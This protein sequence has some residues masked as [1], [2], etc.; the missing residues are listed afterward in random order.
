MGRKEEEEN[1]K[2]KGEE[3][4]EKGEKEKGRKEK[5]LRREAHDLAHFISF[6]FISFL[7]PIRNGSDN[8]TIKLK[9]TGKKLNTFFSLKAVTICLSSISFLDTIFI[10]LTSV[11]FL[12]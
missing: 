7:F 9:K 3:E 5:I 1:E 6:Y 12:I 8:I 11:T 4:G 10:V 2:E